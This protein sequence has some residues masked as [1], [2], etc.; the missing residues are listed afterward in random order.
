MTAIESCMQILRWATGARIT[1]AIPGRIVWRD[2]NGWE[3]QTD[4]P[5]LELVEKSDRLQYILAEGI[6]KQ[7]EYTSQLKNG[8]PYENKVTIGAQTKRLGLSDGP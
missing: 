6:D 7:R 8:L 5:R 3:H 1:E 4:R 2:E